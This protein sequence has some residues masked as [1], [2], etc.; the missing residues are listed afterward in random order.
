[1]R[2]GV[3]LHLLLDAPFLLTPFN[4]RGKEDFKKMISFFL[5][6][7]S[8]LFYLSLPSSSFILNTCKFEQL[9]P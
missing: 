3:L 5:P 8:N 2:K 6:F 7:S 4:K 1:M 9:H